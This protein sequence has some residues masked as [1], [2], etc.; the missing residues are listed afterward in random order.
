ML[1]HDP[2]TVA[3]AFA[4]ALRVVDRFDLV[5]FAVRDGLPGTPAYRAFAECFR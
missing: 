2:I 5:V 4:D 3:G 1:R